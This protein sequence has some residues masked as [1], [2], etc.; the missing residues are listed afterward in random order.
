VATTER[1]KLIIRLLADTGIRVS[2]LPG[3]R[4]DDLAERDRNHCIRVLGIG[5]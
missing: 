1:D 3:L 5:D 2:E 4:V